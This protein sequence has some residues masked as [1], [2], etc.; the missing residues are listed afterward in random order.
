LLITLAPLPAVAEDFYIEEELLA[1][2]PE[3][4]ARAIR[5]D[6]SAAEY[7]DCKFI[8][9]RVEL[10]AKWKLNGYVA[11]TANGCAWAAA[12]GPIWVVS[13]A[14]TGPELILSGQGYSLTLGKQS[15]VGLRNIATSAGTAGWYSEDL[16]KF[17]GK[18]YVKVRQKN[19]PPR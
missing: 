15:S 16:W 13:L 6:S 12:S 17:G 9:K 10:S 3:Q 4:V 8:G 5:N 2:V 1:A 11:T 19:G 7:Q 18:H 14:N